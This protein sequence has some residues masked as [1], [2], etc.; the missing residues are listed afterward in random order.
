MGCAFGKKSP[1]DIM[2]KSMERLRNVDTLL[3]S[4]QT[5]YEHQ[6]EEIDEHVKRGVRLGTPKKDLLV[7][8]RKKKIIAQYTKQCSAK[9][10]QVIHKTYALEQLRLTSM[11][12]EAMKSTA[13]VFKTFTKLHNVEK[14]EQ[15]QANIEDYHD[16]VMEIDTIIGQDTVDVDD[17]ELETELGELYEETSTA[18]TEPPMATFPS[19][20]QDEI[21]H[22]TIPS[23][24]EYG[25]YETG[26]VQTKLML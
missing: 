8:L 3:A 18:T 23:R 6:M 26:R 13:A 25:T 22:D 2:M 12:L 15:L 5:K 1:H 20:P 17:D 10:E 11:Q 14:I 16:Q 19:V 9:R 24:N 7:Q 4:M 21:T